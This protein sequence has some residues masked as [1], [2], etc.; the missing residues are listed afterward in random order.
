[1]IIHLDYS[2]RLHIQGVGFLDVLKID[3]SLL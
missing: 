2:F 1:M 3:L